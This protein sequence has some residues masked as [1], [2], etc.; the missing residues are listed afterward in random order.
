MSVGRLL[1]LKRHF[2]RLL[3]N[4]SSCG[5]EKA[6]PRAQ[7]QATCRYGVDISRY[8]YLDISSQHPLCGAQLLVPL[9]RLAEVHRPVLAGVVGDVLGAWTLLL[10][11]HQHFQSSQPFLPSLQKGMLEGWR[12]IC[13]IMKK[14][15]VLATV[16]DTSTTQNEKM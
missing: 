15:E 14:V 7:I 8:R 13:L 12:A 9:R 3:R 16:A 2:R 6:K 1:N 5:T 10:W 4:A 11:S